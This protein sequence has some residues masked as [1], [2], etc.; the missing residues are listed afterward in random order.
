MKLDAN[1]CYRALSAR[2]AR[3]DGLFFVGVKTTG[4]YCRPVCRA[5]TPGRD[6]CVFFA[7]PVEAERDGFR[8]CLRCRPELAPGSAPV[9]SLPRV[10]AS[11][12]SRIE[13]GAMNEAGLES[14]AREL[15]V[16][17][18][19]LRRAMH[20]ELGVS[21]VELAQSRR[22]A[23][24]KQL[25]QDT[26]LP[27]A[28]VAFASGFQSVRRFNALF[29]ASFG[30]TPS[31]LRGTRRLPVPAGGTVSL[32]LE[33]RP[34]YDWPA[35]RAFL[36][37]R[38]TPGVECVE[39][40]AYA[41]TVRLGAQRGWVRVSPVAGR[42]AL[43]AE[44]S[45]SLAGALMPLVAR[46]RRMFDLDA[47]PDVLNTHLSRDRR[48]AALVRARPGLRVPG[49]FDG[50][51]TAV[52]AVLGQQVSVAAA[53][54]L[55]GRLVASLGEPLDTG[56]SALTH[57]PP[58]P[59]QVAEVREETLTALGI[60]RTRAHSLR[61]LARAVCMGTV[62]LTP[63]ADPERACEQ[64]VE[65]PG[66]GDWTAQYVAMRALAWPDAFPAGDLVL[67]KALGGVTTAR[68]RALAEPWRPWRA[69]AALH[70]WTH[71]S[72]R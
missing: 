14:L 33:Y 39:G 63:Q 24:A 62:D 4:I 58:L 9:D 47:R 48:L 31:A 22:M 19:H 26:R 54:T 72:V 8:A 6:R 42:A 40:D 53:T 61:A 29:R 59:E 43:R 11:A 2:D 51:D 37:A 16:T 56:H 60:L 7:R 52:R 49:A 15:G 34:P 50:F 64:L 68:A 21:P 28:E 35:V 66:F 5:R 27:M 65:L 36:A 67:R 1:A 3:F 70:L 25:L 57:L 18:R 17:S 23:L 30:R 41:R 44:V 55:S 10:V 38:A 71:A 32:T 69:Y 46:L 13:A 12:V 20:A 45:P